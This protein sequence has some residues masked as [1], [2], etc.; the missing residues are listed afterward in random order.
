[1]VVLSIFWSCWR[2]ELPTGDMQ[3]T[4]GCILTQEQVSIL[5]VG[6][7]GAGLSLAL[8]LR[9][10]GIRSLLI[11]RRTDVS[12]YPRARTLNFR[13]LEVLRALGLSAQVQAAGASISRVY[14]KDTLAAGEQ[15]ELLNPATLVEHMEEISPEPF[16]WYCPQS[17]LEPLLRDVAT[18]QGVDVR[19]GNELLAFV[20][21]EAGVVATIKERATGRVR[22]V[23]A[24]Y[25]VA[26]D[27]T[28]SSVRERLAIPTWGQGEL[29]EGQIFIYFRANWGE[30]VQGYAADAIVTTHEGG[31]GMF[32]VTDQNRGMCVVTYAP[33]RGES[34]QEYTFVRCRELICTALGKPEIDVEVID[35]ADWRPVQRV[36]EHF[37]QER[38]FLVGDAAHTVPPYLGLGVNTAI[39]SAQNLAWKLA[40]VLKG[41]AAPHLLTTY[42]T[43]R[44]PVGLLAAE[45]SMAGPAAVLFEQELRGQSLLSV[46]NPLPLLA[47][48]VGYRYCSNAVLAEDSTRTTGT[49]IELLEPLTFCGLPGSRVPHVWLARQGQQISTLDLLDGRFVLLGGTGGTVWREAALA[50]AVHLGV[51][52]SVSL[53]DLDADLLTLETGWEDRMGI[54]PEGALLLRPDGFV[55]WRCRVLPASP[56]LALEQ[57]VTHI[58]GDGPWRTGRA[59]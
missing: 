7:G 17:R 21:D 8:L 40:A 57:A 6:A 15:T 14:R 13:T 47:P 48:I 11:E 3:T 45:Q 12:W 20:Q 19:Y 22:D 33:I 24:R 39:Q 54:S 50:V 25:L 59:S 35:V 42:Q 34:A 55:A 30:L 37:Q 10:Q 16:G 27:G 51:H 43:E 29:A 31:R 56:A 44:H 36:A 28:H 52:L 1:M 46:K 58:L 23:R 41:Q 5:I 53:P 38:V 2:N 4:G 18:Q 32:L 49:G 26:A 9:Q